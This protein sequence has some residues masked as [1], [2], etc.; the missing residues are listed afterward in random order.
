MPRVLLLYNQFPYDY[1]NIVEMTE[2]LSRIASMGFNAVW[3]NPIQKTETEMHS[4]SWLDIKEFQ[5]GHLRKFD[6]G[7]KEE[8]EK[9]FFSMCA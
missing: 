2:D 8:K 9:P 1:H 7:I 6:S 5:S 4:V 3:I